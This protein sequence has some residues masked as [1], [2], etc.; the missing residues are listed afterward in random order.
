[1]AGALLLELSGNADRYQLHSYV[2]LAHC[3]RSAFPDL[4]SLR[5]Y[6]GV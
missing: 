3:R 1:V 4:V 5:S 6:S 2:K